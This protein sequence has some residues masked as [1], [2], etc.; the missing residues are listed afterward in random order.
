MQWASAKIDCEPRDIP[1]GVSQFINVVGISKD[2]SG[3]KLK[4]KEL[5][6]SHA[7]LKSFKG[8]YRFAVLV[9]GDFAKA[10]TFSLDV[11]Y[12][13]D[14][15]QLRVITESHVRSQARAWLRILGARAGRG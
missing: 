6:A 8:T 10:A 15:N 2:V 11:D 12:K 9:S 14:W 3:W 13:G 4:T 1:P 5:F 7:A